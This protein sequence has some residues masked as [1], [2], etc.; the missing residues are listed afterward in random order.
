[1]LR[2]ER[3]LVGDSWLECWFHLVPGGGCRRAFDVG[4]GSGHNTR[5][6]LEHGFEV[7]AIDISERAVELCRR[8]APEARVEWADVR[9]GL[10][11]AG[12]RF[13]LIVVDVFVGRNAG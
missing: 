3:S 10:P 13:E 1:M 12:D 6:L 9:E 4:C 5:L 2:G 7:T 11:F 8:E